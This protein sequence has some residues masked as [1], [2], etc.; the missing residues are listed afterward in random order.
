MI[1]LPERQLVVTLLS[2]AKLA[3]ARQQPACARH[4]VAFLLGTPT[5]TLTTSARSLASS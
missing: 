2:E 1:T 5:T 4:T 3:G